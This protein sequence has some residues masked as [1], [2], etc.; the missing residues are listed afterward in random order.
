MSLLLRGV[1]IG[2]HV[3]T[4]TAARK[5]VWNDSDFKEDDGMP[6]TSEQRTDVCEVSG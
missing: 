6:A 1:T 5:F 2:S 4:D 3:I